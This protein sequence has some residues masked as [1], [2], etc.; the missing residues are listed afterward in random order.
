LVPQPGT[1]GDQ[2]N[3][4][5][6][7]LHPGDD[8][9]NVPLLCPGFRV[10]AQPVV[11]PSDGED[12]GAVLDCDAVGAQMFGQ[13]PGQLSVE[14]GPHLIELFQHGHGHPTDGQRLS[15]LQADTDDDRRPR[16]LLDDRV[17]QRVGV[18]DGVQKVQTGAWP[19]LVE[20]V[21]RPAGRDGRGC[22]SCVVW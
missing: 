21:D 13:R 12:L 7:R 3:E 9:D 8:E 11:V 2:V 14:R 20:T 5:G 6:V 1:R 4:R 10:D 19:Q 15:H 22:R 16:T 17:D 18:I